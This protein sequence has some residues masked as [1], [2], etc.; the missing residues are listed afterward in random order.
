MAYQKSPGLVSDTIGKAPSV[1]RADLTKNTAKLPIKSGIT[2]RM[3][4]PKSQIKR[5]GK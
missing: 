4:Y 3:S 2:E 5:G 1:S